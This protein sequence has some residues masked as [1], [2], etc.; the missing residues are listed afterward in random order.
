MSGV[1]WRRNL[2]SRSC[3]TS[4]CCSTGGVV[5]LWV[6]VAFDGIRPHCGGIPPRPRLC[7]ILLHGGGILLSPYLFTPGMVSLRYPTSLRQYPASPL[8]LRY[9]SSLWRHPAS[10]LSLH[11]RRGL[12]AVSYFAAAVSCL[13][14]VI[15]VSFLAVAVSCLVRVVVGLYR[16]LV[17]AP[18]YGCREVGLWRVII[19]WVKKNL[20]TSYRTPPFILFPSLCGIT[21]CPQD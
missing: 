17:A 21:A 5:S 14:L 10:P 8:S 20:Q 11:A 2:V 16:C 4:P 7:G 12:V 18:V 9:P 3:L 15:A 1:D 13:A 19:D 6:G